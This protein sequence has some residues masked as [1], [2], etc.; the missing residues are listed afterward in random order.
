VEEVTD[1]PLHRDRVCGIDIGKAVMAVTVRVPS[2]R[3]PSRRAQETREFGTTKREVLRL[4]DWLR[5]WQ[6][7]AVVMEATGDYWKPVFCRLEAESFECVLADAKQ[8]RNLPGRPKRDKSDSRWLAVCFERGAVASCFV[9]TPEFRV[10]REHTRYRRDLTG[11]RTREK[12]RAEKLLESAAVKLSSVLTD[13]HGVTGRDVMGRLI[14]GER[15]PKAL[16]RLARGRAKAKIPQLE[17]ALE[18]AEFLTPELAALLRAMLERTGRIDADI[19]ALAQVTGRLLAPYEEQLQQAES[20]PGWGRRAAQDVIAETGTDMSRFPTPGHLAS[21]AGRTPLDRQSGG[22]RGKAKVKKGNRYIGAVTGETAAAAGKTQTREG[23]RYRR[24][25]R[26]RGKAKAIVAT[27]NTQ[28]RACHVLLS[29]PGMRY[30]DLGWDY[31]EQERNTARQVSHHVGKLSSLGYEVTL[32]RRPEPDEPE[33][34]RQPDPGQ[35]PAD[36]TNRRR[37]L[38]RARELSNFRVSYV[39]RFRA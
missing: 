29:H 10:I 34:R 14:A 11:E 24:V 13:V 33:T 4:A 16:A 38:P 31:Y 2:D 22:R 12:Q 3:D 5:C 17:E 9:A 28:M 20:M 37:L 35:N 15:D 18:G 1:E 8:V 23:A 6:V 32:A 30:H 21:W 25:S 36:G 27:G 26:R 7:P 39:G 19:A